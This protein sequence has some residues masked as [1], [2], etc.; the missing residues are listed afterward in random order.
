[1]V[2]IVKAG[3][4]MYCAND[5]LFCSDTGRWRAEELK[6][7]VIVPEMH[8]VGERYYPADLGTIQLTSS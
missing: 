7:L 8:A 2:D 3:R 1:M 6:M 4:T 5:I